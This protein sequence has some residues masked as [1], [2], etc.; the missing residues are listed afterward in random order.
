MNGLIIVSDII[1]R[2]K[3][4]H[5]GV[6]VE[7]VAQ[8]I[9]KV[10]TGA[11]KILNRIEQFQNVNMNKTAAEE[12]GA[13]ALDI[14]YPDPEKW[15]MWDKGKS[16]SNLIEPRRPEDSEPNLW[17]IFNITQE[18]IIKGKPFMHKKFAKLDNLQ[19]SREIVSI[20]RSVGI[21]KRLW[22]LTEKTANVR[23]ID[24]LA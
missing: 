23:L 21:N 15:N 9:D 13:K 4:K 14:V 18:K 5:V 22:D 2:E 1:G 6:T 8:I 10:V 3:I 16:V 19:K 7:R 20:E 24:E 11:P 12:Y 17:S